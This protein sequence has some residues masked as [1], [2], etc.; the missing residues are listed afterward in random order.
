MRVVTADDGLQLHVSVR[1]HGPP[2]VLLHSWAADHAAWGQIA[3]ELAHRFT[4]HAWDARGHGRST[5]AGH[6]PPVVM[7]MARDLRT[8]LAHFG[9]EQPTLVAH[10]MG[11]LTLWQAVAD[12]GCAGIGQVC[13]IDQSPR[14]ITDDQ[15]R[16]GIYGDWPAGRNR[17]FMAALRA[18]FPGSVLRLLAEGHNDK[19]R[20]QVAANTRGIQRLR[21]SLARLDPEPL[22]VCW[23]SLGQADYRPVLPALTVP[24]LLVYGTASNYYGTETARYV[25]DRIPG[26]VLHLFEGADHSPHLAER[27]RFLTL[28]SAFIAGERD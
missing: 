19:T 22:V 13:I 24:T 9:L 3:T 11:A 21:E 12:G 27:E 26:S 17:A 23:D 18:D 2:V 6:A 5:V 10:S 1:G 20:Q 14:L 28:L 16:L 25:A 15:W 4:V 8:V 7:R